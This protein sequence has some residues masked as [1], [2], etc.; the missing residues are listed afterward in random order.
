MKV[1]QGVI[2]VLFEFICYKVFLD[3]FLQKRNNLNKWLGRFLG[4]VIIVALTII[5]FLVH[6]YT[7]K[8][9]LIVLTFLLISKIYNKSTLFQSMVLSAI[10]YGILVGIDYLCMVVLKYL[11]QDRYLDILYGSN[12]SATIVILL[13]KTVLFLAIL[14]IRREWSKEN[15]LALISN[16]EWIF[17]LY[18]PLF[19][20]VSMAVM[21]FNFDFNHENLDALL[22]IAFGLVIMNFM[23]F[24]LMHYIVKRER[25]IQNSKLIQ[26]R[27]KNQMNIYRNMHDS[28]EQ[29]KKKIHDYKNQLNCIQGMLVN[30]KVPEAQEYIANLTGSL[31]KDLD[32]IFTN[33]TVVDTVINQKYKYAK[34]KGIMMILKV[35][36]LSEL[37]INE[38]DLVTLLS[39]ILDNAIEACEKVQGDKVIKFKM[40]L[41]DEQILISTQNPIKE[42]VNIVDNR[43]V[44]SK[45]NKEEHGIGLLNVSSVVDKYNGIYVIKN[46]N[47]WFY[48]SIIIPYSSRRWRTN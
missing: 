41:E 23:V 20:I 48:L 15:D 7:L 8:C 28:Y 24:Y 33:H 10:Y 29:Y 46:E 1:I 18:F 31:I 40:I 34:S 37:T 5:A 3:I 21:V 32:T 36:D 38:E 11:L 26:E 17:F 45:S 22:F 25:E 30:E 16:I 43:I 13:C 27:T 6:I 9:C 44:T 47:G 14:A 35:N 4:V 19:T 39:N 2:T 42:P 12:V